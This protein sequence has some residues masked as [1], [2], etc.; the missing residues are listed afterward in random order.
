MISQK[1][2]EDM[3]EGSAPTIVLNCPCCG[4]ADIYSTRFRVSC[5]ACGL[6]TPDCE[7]N[8]L[9]IWNRRAPTTA[10]AFADL[11]HDLH[12]GMRAISSLQ[13]NHGDETTYGFRN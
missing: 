8:A 9:K 3:R 2:I 12:Q 13:I 5:N 1:D 4:S 6:K 11:C 7:E 10:K